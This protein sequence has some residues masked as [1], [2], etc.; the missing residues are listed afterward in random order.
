MVR[1]FK[2]IWRSHRKA[3][4]GHP[5]SVFLPLHTIVVISNKFFTQMIEPVE[6]GRFLFCSTGCEA[7]PSFTRK[8]AVIGSFL[9]RIGS[10][11]AM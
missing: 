5:P 11:I 4:G 6:Y 10:L 8:L 1:S 3:E 2:G 9:S 7:Q